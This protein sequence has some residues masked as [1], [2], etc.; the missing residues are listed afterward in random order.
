MILWVDSEGPDQTAHMCSLIWAF[1]VCIGS[2]G[3]FLHC[4]AHINVFLI[5]FYWYII[6][7][8]NTVF[9]PFTAQCAYFFSK[10][11][12]KCLV[13]ISLQLAHT[14]IKHWTAEIKF[15]CLQQDWLI[16]SQL[17]HEY[18]I[19]SASEVKTTTTTNINTY[20]RKT[21]KKTGIYLRIMISCF[22]LFTFWRS[23]QMLCLDNQSKHLGMYN[24]WNLY[25]TKL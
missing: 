6:Q 13:K 16:D 4:A 18:W 25:W 5:L 10:L 9:D 1:T 23:G 22:I 12:S 7:K 21:K 11:H 20:L 24:E 14:K 3:T 17:S 15:H 2:E 8:Y 19:K